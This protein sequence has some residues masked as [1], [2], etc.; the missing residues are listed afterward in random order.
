[1]DRFSG[2]RPDLARILPLPEVTS[3]LPRVFK[4]IPRKEEVVRK[5]KGRLLTAG[6]GLGMAAVLVAAVSGC[7]SSGSGAPAPNKPA[8]MQT[9]RWYG[10]EGTPTWVNTLDPSQVTDSISNNVLNMVDVN[11]VKLLPSGNVAP[12]MAS[13][14]KESA[15][16]KVYTFTLRP[17]LHFNNGHPLTAQDV[18]WSIERALAPATKSP[19]ALSYLGHIVGAGPY[20]SGKAKSLAG[21]KVLNSRTVQISLDAPIAFFLKT[22]TYPTADIL[23]PKVMS[24]KAAQTYLTNTCSANVSP[25]PFM[26]VCRNKSSA[27]TSFYAPGHTP[28]ISLVPNPAYYGTKPKIKVVMPAI[29]DSQTNYKDFQAGGIDVTTIPTTQIA[30]SRHKAGFIEFPTSEVD[31]IT[32][33]E[34]TAPF[35]N[36]HCRLALAYSINRDAI[37]N[38]IL[39]GSQSSTYAVVPKG[40]LGYYPGADN[41]HYN[42][43]K[44]KAELKLCPG[45]IHNVNLTY[46]HTSVD[47]DNEYNAIAH[48]W[49]V[50]GA[51]VNVSPLTFNSWLNVVG[52]PLPSTKTAITENLWIEDYPDP[53]D[54][55][56]LL[57][58]AGQNY[59]IGLFNNPQY[60]QL[61]DQAA[62]EANP[63]KRAQLYIKAQH[64]AL[65][66]GAWISVGNANG[67]ALVNPKVHGLLGSEAFGILV[68]KNNDWSTVTIS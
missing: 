3:V 39:H 62:I 18:A 36:V 4:S 51:N 16:H 26:F 29:P 61:V 2:D 44:A 63:A 43:A 30:V 13:T 1:M 41:P 24:G 45:G 64:I 21:V 35:N 7:G 12:Y 38:S 17:N 66:Q 23:D 60:N 50:I 5:P 27:V 15:N 9:L 46:Q 19:V 34:S 22:L 37:N 67:Y 20:S 65:S 33:N 10:L 52:K 42:P 31:Y 57:L 49:S 59:D 14:W 55:A 11:L 53:Y 54:Y 68:P 25:G 6:L 58:R 48:M 32:P 40:M 8:T 47:I 56:T 28:Q